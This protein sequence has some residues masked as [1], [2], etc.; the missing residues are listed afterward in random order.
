MVCAEILVL[1][2]SSPPR[3]RH[4][5]RQLSTGPEFEFS[6]KLSPHVARSADRFCRPLPYLALAWYVGRLSWPL[7]GMAFVYW[8]VLPFAVV[9]SWPEHSEAPLFGRTVVGTIGSIGLAA[10]ALFM[11]A[12]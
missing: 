8:L 1:A 3:L 12:R 7:A 11:L 10:L 5:P 4:A 2:A 9:W 6:Q